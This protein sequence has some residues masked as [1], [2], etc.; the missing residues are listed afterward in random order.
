MKKKHKVMLVIAIVF[1]IIAFGIYYGYNFATNYVF[2]KMYNY[3]ITEM[4]DKEKEKIPPEK[5]DVTD[6]STPE[7]E[8]QH[9]T[10][11][12]S[13]TTDGK[14]VQSV[15]ENN[16]TSST[17]V[18]LLKISELTPEQLAEIQALITS[19]DKANAI[20]MVK[21][22]LTKDDKREFKAMLEKGKIDYARVKQIL[23]KRL[24]TEQKKKIYGYYEKYSRIYF[25]SKQ[26]QN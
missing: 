11:D 5:V 21:S 24:N 17:D 7:T 10:E 19:E 4:I 23:S 1:A 18:A 15:P 13:G 25:E 16:K 2:D 22:A 20:A 8:R 3:V 12:I 6:V 14:P 26:S 9:N